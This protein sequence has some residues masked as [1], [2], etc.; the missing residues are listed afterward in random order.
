MADTLD[1]VSLLEARDFLG[2]DS[3]DSSDDGK[4]LEFITGITPVVEREVGPVVARTVTDIIYATQTSACPMVTLPQWPVVSLTSGA[5]LRDDSAVDVSAMVTDKGVLFTKDFTPLPAGPWRLTYV[6]GRSP[7]P[8]NI[9]NGALE[10]LDLAWATQR[11]QDAPAF[12][13]SYRAMAW[14]KSGVLALGFA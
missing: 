9:K 2:F 7:V 8:E 11:E 14:L 12:L 1:I 13:V 6:V 3:G 10:I 5:L 4:L